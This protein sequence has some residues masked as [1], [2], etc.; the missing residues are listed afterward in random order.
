[1]DESVRTGVTE[2]GRR[3]LEEIFRLVLDLPPDAD[4]STL[5]RLTTSQ[6][7]SL[8]HVSLTAAIESEFGMS[9]DS[10]DAERLTSF[11]AALLL[12]EEKS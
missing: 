1:M 4:S 2:A 7:D 12:I 6:W 10:S 8:A 3:K 5:R 11:Q 9:L